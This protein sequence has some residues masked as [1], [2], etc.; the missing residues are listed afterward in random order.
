MKFHLPLALLTAVLSVHAAL[1]E[2][3]GKTTI[4]ITEDSKVVTAETAPENVAGTYTYETQ[5]DTVVST[6]VGDS[7]SAITTGDKSYNAN[8]PAGAISALPKEYVN[9]DGKAHTATNTELTIGN[10]TASFVKT[11]AVCVDRGDSF[12]FQVYICIPGIDN[13]IDSLQGNI[14]SICHFIVCSFKFKYDNGIS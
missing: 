2:D 4:Y 14:S 10:G 8:A 11:Y 12:V 13:L 6:F 7:K 9:S 3:S 1:A 5:G